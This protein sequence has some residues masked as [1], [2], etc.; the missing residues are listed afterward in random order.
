MDDPAED[1][2]RAVAAPRHL[3]RRAF[4]KEIPDTLLVPGVEPQSISH[5]RPAGAKRAAASDLG[6]GPGPGEASYRRKR[7]LALI[8]VIIVALSVP[9][10]ILALLLAG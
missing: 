8:S 7:M 2:P 9:T 10:L 1:A 3:R 5:G 6:P 4:H